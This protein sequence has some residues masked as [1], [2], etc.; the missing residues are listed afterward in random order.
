[1]PSLTRPITCIIMPLPLPLPLLALVYL[2]SAVSVL[3][4]NA[5]M[6][7]NNGTASGQSFLVLVD[8]PKN[9]N[10]AV[11]RSSRNRDIRVLDRVAS[12]EETIPKRTRRAAPS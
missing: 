8:Y 5:G 11:V 4:T 12:S 3:S 1:M 10:R 9:V 7:G 6:E 2:A